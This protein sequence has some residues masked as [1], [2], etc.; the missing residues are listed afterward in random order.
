MVDM[1]LLG[2]SDQLNDHFRLKGFDNTMYK[3]TV[4]DVTLHDK[5]VDGG[6]DEDTLESVILSLVSLEEENV[7]KNNYPLKLTGTTV[8]RERSA[9]YINA[10]LLFSSKYGKYETALKAISQV[11]FCFQANKKFLFTVDGEDQEAILQMHNMGF[12]NLN[13]LWT[14]LGGRYLPSVIYKA[15]VLMYQQSPPVNGSA[16]VDISASETN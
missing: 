14:V 12:E 4:G 7:L 2:V 16:I 6:N 10:Y 15:R 8:T 3:C 11:I 1:L 9:V 5:T 13:N